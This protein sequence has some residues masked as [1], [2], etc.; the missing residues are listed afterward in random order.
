MLQERG[1]GGGELWLLLS[2]CINSVGRSSPPSASAGGKNKKPKQKKQQESRDPPRPPPQT[3]NF[4][5]RTAALIKT[6]LPARC[7]ISPS[8]THRPL[9][10]GRGRFAPPRF[11]PAPGSCLSAPLKCKIYLL[12]GALPIPLLARLSRLV[13]PDQYFPSC[14]KRRR[15]SPFP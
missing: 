1:K 15:K 11:V 4:T 5:F 14:A 6:E 13:S 2:Q 9:A 7:N 10:D 12:L 3:T 8:L